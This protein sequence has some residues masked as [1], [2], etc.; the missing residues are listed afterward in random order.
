MGV[1][2]KMQAQKVSKGKLALE[3]FAL[4]VF[5]IVGFLASS[6]CLCIGGDIA[7]GFKLTLF[8]LAFLRLTWSVYR[9][10][11]RFVDYFVYFALVIGFCIWVESRF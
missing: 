2:H 5:F 10:T 4:L 8:L 7:G 6:P 1:A 3:I 9:H 11:F